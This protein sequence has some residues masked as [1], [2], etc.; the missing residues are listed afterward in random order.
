M[1]RLI[2]YTFCSVFAPLLFIG[3]SKK[4]LEEDPKGSL[5]PG[6]FYQTAKDLEMAEA[7]LALQLNG[8]FNVMEGVHYGADD[9]TSKRAGN[10]IEFSDFDVFNANSSNSRMNDW[11]GYFYK[12]IK[13]A[14]SLI[15]NFEK[16]ESATEEQ[17]NA[18]GGYGY[19]MRAI[20]YFFLTRTW[21]EVP[22]PL[23]TIP[24]PNRPKAAVEEIYNLIVSDLQKAET[25]LPDHWP[26]P[27]NQNGVDI[28]ATRGSAKALLANVYLTMAGWPLKQTDKYALAA[29]KAK[30][31]IDERATWGYELLTDYAD[32]WKIGNKYNKE[33]VFA[34]YYN[35]DVPEWNWENG[36]MMGPPA[37]APDYEEGGWDDGYG[38]ISFYNRFPAGPRKDA[39][40]QKEYFVKN[41]PDNVVTWE[42]TLQKHPYFLKYR[43]DHNYDWSTHTI[44]DWWGSGTNFLIRYPEVLLTYAE[45]KAMSSAPDASAYAAVNQ[46][47]KRAGL[48]D[49]PAGLSQAEFREAVLEERGWEFA[50]ENGIR[51]FDLL[52][53]ETVGKA[54]SLRH[55]SEVPLIN[56]PD[57]AAHTHYWAPI[58]VND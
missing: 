24:T 45:A 44:N 43:D 26:E 41:D 49:L 7:A 32:I 13:S 47:R 27:A 30:E 36:N 51:W 8:A 50:A 19:F 14:N 18:A 38:E 1:K 23:E 20:S 11:W 17:R 4:I 2:L 28:F 39:T 25:M 58:P 57:D 16:A 22:M 56:Q 37:L 12:T 21:G 15:D 48:A 53:T 34:C 40:Y 6:N 31:V 3:C 10:K 46:V 29:D 42:G 54:N 35:N 52:R 33:A 9:I 5:T 55:A